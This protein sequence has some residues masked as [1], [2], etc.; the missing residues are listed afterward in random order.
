[1]IPLHLLSHWS[2]LDGVPSIGEIIEPLQLASTEKSW[3]GAPKTNARTLIW[4]KTI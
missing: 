2:L 3:A 1:M 4:L